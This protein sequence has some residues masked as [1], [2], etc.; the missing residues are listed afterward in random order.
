VNWT[1]TRIL[2][3]LTVY[4]CEPVAVAQDEH[5]QHMK[6]DHQ[7]PMG[8]MDCS[9]SELW[10][11]SF[12]SCQPLNMGEP[13]VKMWM[14]HGNAFLVQTIAEGPRGRDQ[15]ASPNMLMS[16]IGSSIGER[17]YLNLNLMLTAEKWT[18][19]KRGYP[20]LLQ[21]GEHDE[22]D[23][24]YIDGQ[25]PHSSPI[26][27]LTLSDTIRLGE[28]KDHLKL[29]FAPRGQATEGPTAYMHR[30]TGMVNPD[31]PLGHHIGQDVSHITSTVFGAS[32]GLGRTRIEASAFNGTE[33]EPTHVDLPFGV[34][35]SYAGR[36]IY[37][38]SD[39]WSAMTSAAFLKDPEPHDPSISKIHRY[40]AS[41]YNNHKLGS[42]WM[43]H[44]SFVFGLVNG[45]DH[46]SAL[47]SVLEEFWFHSMDLPHH[48]WGRVEFVERA[49]SELAIL[50]TNNSF[51]PKWVTALTVGY[52]YDLWKLNMGKLGAGVSVTKNFL[53]AEF[54]NAYGGDPWSGRVFIQ[55]TGMKR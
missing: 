21:I 39:E 45:Y 48:F 53:P 44:N 27:G 51:D 20:E 55:I 52:T 36:L 47:R 18:F 7:M 13:S 38:F 12:G 31:A 29:F 2:F 9:D 11:F 46:V 6:H 22:E 5:A 4:F 10:D 25:H 40:S 28:G 34:L 35:N 32:L 37:E 24:P 33:P 54:E 43:F 49:A 42:G 16:D 3:G 17:H 1:I 23:Q 8:P 41:V 30:P 26:M 15:F 19:P 50:G 14:I